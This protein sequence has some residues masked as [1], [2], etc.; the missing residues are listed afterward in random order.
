MKDENKR[1]KI[2][3]QLQ[4]TTELVT[5]MDTAKE[6]ELAFTADTASLYRFESRGWTCIS[7]GLRQA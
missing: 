5:L 3:Y 2:D 7:K 4:K 6:G 1:P